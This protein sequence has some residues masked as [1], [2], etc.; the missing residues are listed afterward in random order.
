MKTVIKKVIKDIGTRKS[1][2]DNSDVVLDAHGLFIVPGFIDL[3]FHGAMGKDAMDADG[4]SL[5]VMSDFCAA[6]GVTSFYPTT[7]SA[8]QSDIL[9][10]IICVKE[11]KNKVH[12]AQILGVH[13]EGPYVDLKYRGAQST[14]MIRIPD[15]SEYLPWFESGVVKIITCAPEVAGCIEF[16]TEAINNDVRISIGHS[17]ADYDQVI[18][19]ANLGVT[20]ATHI[21]NGMVGL[22]HRDPGTVGGIFDDDRILAQ[23]I[24]DGVHLHPA[25]VRLILKAKTNSKIILIT[26]SIRGA[27]LPDGDYENKGQK[28]SVRNA[29]ARTP[30]GGLSG[31]TLT[32]DQA[33]RNFLNFTNCRLEDALSM[34]TLVPAI[35]MGISDR[36]GKI[37]VGGD[38]DIVLLNNN[39]FVEKTIVNGQIVYSKE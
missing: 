14:G 20:Q 13:V 9:D 28:F 22:H 8:S 4:T 27:G 24:C 37:V 23:V 17:Q 12:G 38:A 39:L 34:V 33:L 30:E 21:F 31:S 11:N 19:A 29:I 10:A 35:E 2:D 36:K 32:M 16:I 18:S 1:V 5:Q 7:W 6:H 15:K 25:I 3:H 26:D